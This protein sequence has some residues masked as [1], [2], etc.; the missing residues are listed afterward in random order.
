MGSIGSLIKMLLGAGPSN[1]AAELSP[2]DAFQRIK[3]DKRIQLVDVRSAEEN[4]EGR[5]T[6]SKLFP[7]HE[8]ANRLGE[9]DK[10]RPLI[11]YCRSGNRSGMALRLLQDKGFTNAAHIAGGISSWGR[12]GLPIE[13]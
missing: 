4:R 10:T 11:L 12:S 7:L 9:I 13:S 2:Q 1:P 5:I 3:G 6:G 8:L